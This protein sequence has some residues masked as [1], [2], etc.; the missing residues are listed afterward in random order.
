M[1]LPPPP[2]NSGTVVGSMW[3]ALL[4]LQDRASRLLSQQ[5]GQAHA[6]C[7]CA[8]RCVCVGGGGVCVC[9]VFERGGGGLQQLLQPYRVDC[10]GQVKGIKVVWAGR[11]GD[12]QQ[13]GLSPSLPAQTAWHALT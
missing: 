4:L 2:N 9:V 7:H 6:F 13:Q 8:M 10:A 1:Y 12:L 5:Q 3:V 11:G